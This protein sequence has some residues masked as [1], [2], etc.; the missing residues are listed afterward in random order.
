MK[1]MIK[2]AVTFFKSESVYDILFFEFKKKYESLGRIGGNVSLSEYSMEDINELSRFLGVRRDQLLDKGSITLRQFENQLN[3]YKFDG[4]SLKQLLEAYFET[5]LIS[6]KEQAASN[7]Q[8]NQ[9]FFEELKSNYPYV[10]D[11]LSYIE[12]KPADSHWIYRFLEKSFKNFE[13]SVA[14]LN[15]VVKYAPSVPIR[16]PVFAQQMTKNPHG[17]D[18]NQ[19]LGK[20]LV[21]LLAVEKAQ[22]F[23]EPVKVPTT[24]E[25]ITELLFEYNVL[26]DDITNYV[27]V[28]NILAYT[29]GHKKKVWE[30]AYQSH[31]VLNVP[32]RELVD[33]QKLYPAS[34][35][36]EVWIVENSGVFSSLL[37]KIADVPLICTHG[38][39]TL[40]VWRCLDLLVKQDCTLYYSGDF[41]PEG[42]G[43]ANRLLR[44]Y[45]HHV[46]LWKMDVRSYEKS[47]SKEEK[48]SSQRLSQFSN[49]NHSELKE[50][51]NQVLKLQVPGYQEALLDEMI[52]ELK[53]KD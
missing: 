45:P 35:M 15:Q 31:S 48:I 8:R 40:A 29:E 10:N 50:I 11:W 28:A 22:S 17:F 24:N 43:M 38:Q 44:R 13:Q 25:G 51:K 52:E 20:L 3:R 7:L 5:P 16:L 41:D 2:E 19:K 46:Q 30:A 53:K 49:I 32:I 4:L 33:V 39:F 1:Q 47:L 21:H 26:R 12:Q 37:D 14:I 34:S 42:I 23:N 18:R 36:N 9:A 27:S 6:K